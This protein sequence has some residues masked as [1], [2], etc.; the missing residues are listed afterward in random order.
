[1]SPLPRPILWLTLALFS[2]MGESLV[3]YGLLG[4]VVV[5]F[6]ESSFFPIPPDFIQIGLTLP[7]LD[8]ASSGYQPMMAFT[9]ATASMVASVLGSALGWT[10]G[11]Y[12]GERFFVWMVRKNWLSRE[13]FE[14]ARDL[15]NRYD[16]GAIMIAAFTPIPYKLF[17]IAS[18]V[19]GMPLWRLMLA[20]VIGRGGR[21][22][23]VAGLLYWQGPAAVDFIKGKGF[24]LLTLGLALLVVLVAWV[25]YRM[26]RRTDQQRTIPDSPA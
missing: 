22:F 13:K 1:M 6:L 19:S 10:I 24:A 16:M 20:S 25:V 9:F 8:R 12:A 5:S 14:K 21:F 26:R 4:L 11:K 18:G 23:L 15:L 2:E 17:T 7:Y 3:K